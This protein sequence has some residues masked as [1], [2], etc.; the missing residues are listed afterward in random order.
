MKHALL[1]LFERD[2]QRLHDEIAAYTVPADLWK[3]DGQINNTAGNLA[4]HLCGSLNHFIGA[5]LGNTGY[6]RTRDAEFTV[7]DVPQEEILQRIL[8]M[9]QTVLSTL[10]QLPE[11]DLEKTYPLEVFGHPMTTGYFLIHIT[12]HVNYHLGQINYHRRLL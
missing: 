6:V 2:I 1:S 10:E 3:L 5:I 7:K 4:I 8:A 12:G 9:K 11:E